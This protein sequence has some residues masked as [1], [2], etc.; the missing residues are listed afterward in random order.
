MKVKIEPL[1]PGHSETENPRDPIVAKTGMMNTA[2]QLM[3][4][5]EK[6]TKLIR[7]GVCVLE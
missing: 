6:R 7:A 1:L 4:S 3:R 2:T 5:E